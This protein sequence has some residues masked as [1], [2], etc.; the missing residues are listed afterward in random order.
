MKQTCDDCG[1]SFHRFNFGPKDHR[2]PLRCQ[3]CRQKGVHAT[4]RHAERKR[5]ERAFCGN[6]TQKT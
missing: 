1:A 5:V 3:K 4:A 6:L 2:G